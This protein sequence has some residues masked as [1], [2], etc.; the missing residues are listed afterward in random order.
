MRSSASTRTRQEFAAKAVAAVLTGHTGWAE[1]ALDFPN[2]G[3]HT[4][5]GEQSGP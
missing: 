2:T 4:E 1:P 3:S 5:H